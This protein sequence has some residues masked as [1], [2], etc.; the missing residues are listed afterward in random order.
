M[1]SP[2]SVRTS[3]SSSLAKIRQSDNTIQAFE[4][5]FADDATAQAELLDGG[6]PAAATQPLRGM[7]LGVKDIFELSG[8]R[9]GN[10]NRAAF[11]LLVREVPEDDAALVRLL[12]DAGAV[13]TGMTRSTE[14]CW[15][16][17]T[18]TRNPHDIDC[19]PGGSS[20]GSAAAVAADMVTAAIGSQTNGS[21]V[22][23]ASYCGLF[24]YK[25][26]YDRLDLTGMTRISDS[27]DHTG[28]FARDAATVIKLAEVAGNFVVPQHVSGD[29][30]LGVVDTQ[31]LADADDEVLETFT[32]YV[33]QL[34]DAGHTVDS[35]RLPEV[36]APKTFDAYYGVLAPEIYQLHR[37]LLS[38]DLID[39]LG[40]NTVEIL[41]RGRDT[42]ATQ[43]REAE[44]VVAEIRTRV[45]GY[46]DQFD[47]LILPAATS[48]APRTLTYTGSP[49]LSTLSSMAG[50]PITV[51][52][53]GLGRSGLPVGIQVWGR[54]GADQTVLS[55]LAALP[56]EYVAPQ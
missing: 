23:P 45:D 12:R 35:I 28:F 44:K 43:Q 13:L 17:P 55:L 42:T 16:Q 6:D 32:T 54:W 2:T 33:G 22:R 51:I 26:G 37:N 29:Y 47:A 30:R 52:P 11:E 46:F 21:I 53:A 8:R 38:P 34:R 20:S 27:F 19:T 1:T 48:C 15:Y 9:P 39:K 41:Q 31:D 10:G 49:A 24:A 56:S 7:T 14:L 3:V 50:I 18:L 25:S 4:E 5:V 36:L 40:P